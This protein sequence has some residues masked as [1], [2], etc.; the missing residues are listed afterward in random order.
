MK[1]STG[2]G[3]VA[4]MAAHRP[5]GGTEAPPWQRRGKDVLSEVERTGPTSGGPARITRCGQAGAE[6]GERVAD[7]T[8]PT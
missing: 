6:W 5:G 1:T 4:A 3:P 8:T 2:P 7:R